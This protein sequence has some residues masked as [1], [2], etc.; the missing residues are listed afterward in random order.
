M[1]LT[2][3]LPLLGAIAL[4]LGCAAY[5]QPAAPTTGVDAAVVASVSGELRLP[6]LFSDGLVLQ[7]GRCDLVWGWAQAGDS[8][9]VRIH[10]SAVT[11]KAD[12]RGD[13]S[14]RLPELPAGGP[15][16]MEIRN[17]T[18]TR[19]IRDIL[20]GEV[21]LGAGQSNMARTLER[22]PSAKAEAAQLDD[23]EL[24]FFQVASAAR[25][26]PARDVGGRWVKARSDHLTSISGVAY[27]F[28]KELRRAHTPVGMIVTAWGGTPLAAW[29]PYDDIQRNSKLAAVLEDFAV[30]KARREALLPAYRQ[31]LLAWQQLPPERRGSSPRAPLGDDHPNAPANLYQGMIAPVIR[32]GMRGVL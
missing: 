20:V 14:G 8:I 32:Y 13:W 3:R 21:W 1:P 6:A 5:S 23:P 22:I 16:E 27:F 24:R 11:A 15:Y 28:G 12:P 4:L 30:A 31:R 9:E 7:A 19:R 10:G 26:A 29:T 17:G 18:E 25:S 2:I